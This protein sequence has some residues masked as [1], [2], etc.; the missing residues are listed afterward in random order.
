MACE[1]GYITERV[2]TNLIKFAGKKGTLSPPI[3]FGYQRPLDADQRD[4][5]PFPT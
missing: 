5:V 2:E 1:T 4:R 3:A